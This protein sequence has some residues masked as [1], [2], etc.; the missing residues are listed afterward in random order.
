MIGEEVR[1]R[2]EG[3]NLTG[4]QLAA[5]AGMAPSAISQIETGKRT[6][7]SASVIKLAEA[8]GA[9][10]GDLY[11]KKVQAPLPLEPDGGA[12]L[13][14][15][16]DA[17]RRDEEKDS[18]ALARLGASEGLPQSVSQYEEDRVR[19]ELRA[20]GF[21]D[22]LFEDFLWPLVVEANQAARLKE[23]VEELEARDTPP[24]G[25]SRRV[26]F[27]G[28]PSWGESAAD[29]TEAEAPTSEVESR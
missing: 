2:R 21:P 4:A 17:A 15:V 16:L 20:A 27:S 13:E 8:L 25:P 19:A 29:P 12:L 28:G 14:R 9:E 7:S 26:R 11:P 23:R 1:R 24:T 6:P 3:L 10:V 5:R 22:E 18:R